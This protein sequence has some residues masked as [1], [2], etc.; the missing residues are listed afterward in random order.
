ME[1]VILG[2]WVLEVTNNPW[3]VGLMGGFRFWP[4]LLGPFG[5]VVAD[6]FDR[7]LVLLGAQGI[8]AGGSLLLLTL[9]WLGRLE[10]W[11]TFAVILVAG[12]ARTLDNATR[13]TVIG[14]LL[15]RERLINGMALNQ[16]AMNGTAILAPPVGGLLYKFWG[17]G[18]GF[19]AIAA[20]YVLGLCF[21]Y[22]LPSLPVSPAKVGESP[23]RRLIDG[24]DFVRRDEMISALMWLAAIA[25]LCGYPLAYGFLPVFARDVLGTDSVGL[26]I[27][28]GAIGAGS[29]AGSVLLASVR[30]VGHRGRFVIGTM[31]FWMAVLI[32][33]AFSRSFAVSLV[34]LVLIGAAASLSMSTVAAMLMDSSPIPIRGR[35]MGVRMFAI[36]TLPIATTVMGAAIGLLGAPL[37]LIATAGLG[38][39]LTGLVTVRLPS[40]WHRA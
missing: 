17:L 26:G 3:L 29:V 18:S 6:R 22:G 38:A 25:N 9:A 37:T 19:L 31:L 16:V 11:H 39:A 36:V 33:F 27:L 12:M 2:W 30:G 21:T 23:W 24:L 32:F 5:G 8:V 34:L 1:I 7:R 35:V 10:V 14:D 40:L 20:L 13:Q 15:P 4:S 28:A